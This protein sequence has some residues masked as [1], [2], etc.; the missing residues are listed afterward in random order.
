MVALMEVP[1][2][3]TGLIGQTRW[4]GVRAGL[5][6]S[7]GLD[8][9]LTGRGVVRSVLVD[10]GHPGAVLD[11]SSLGIDLAD[12]DVLDSPGL[13]PLGPMFGGCWFVARA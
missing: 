2:I 1:V 8:G 5:V 9:N 12:G 4:G 10:S 13:V 7:G 3:N 6:G 11:R